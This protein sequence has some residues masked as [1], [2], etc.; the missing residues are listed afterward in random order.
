MEA[1]D[2]ITIVIGFV[3]FLTSIASIINSL[4]NTRL[5]QGQVEIEIRERITQARNRIDDM[6]LNS[7][8]KPNFQVVFK[9]AVEEYLNAYN[10][11]CQKYLDRKVD[12]K[13]FR[14]TYFTELVE[15]K[16]N[17]TYKPY[18]DERAEFYQALF[19]VYNSL[20]YPE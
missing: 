12:L 13:R 8:D 2:Y 1:N 9:D 17:D 3:T 18:L 19:K 11:A 15:L 10:E 4:T 16:R 20:V 7:S 6:T 5:L 14:K